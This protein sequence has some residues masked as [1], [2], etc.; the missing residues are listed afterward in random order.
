[1]NPISSVPASLLEGNDGYLHV[2]GTLIS[3]LPEMVNDISPYFKIR[4]DN[5]NVSF[6]WNWTDPMVENADGGFTDGV[7]AILASN[8]PYCLDLQFSASMKE[9]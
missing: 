9:N 1:M 3:E 7:P 4:V 2:G 6:F 8:L 5:T